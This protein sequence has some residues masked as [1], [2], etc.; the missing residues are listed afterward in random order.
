M[1]LGAIACAFVA[2]RFAAEIMLIGN[3]TGR[4]PAA[5]RFKIKQRNADDFCLDFLRLGFD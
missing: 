2:L 5:V 3:A 4:K 1:M